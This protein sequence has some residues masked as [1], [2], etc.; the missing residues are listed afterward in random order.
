[1]SAETAGSAGKVIKVT[2]VHARQN[3]SDIIKQDMKFFIP[4]FSALLIFLFSIFAFTGIVKSAGKVIVLDPGHGG[5]DTGAVYKGLQEKT[6]TLDIAK[7]LKA[8]LEGAG[9]IVYLTREDDLTKSNN[10]RYTLANRVGGNALVSIHLNSSS[11]SSTD[12]TQGF[13]GKKTKDETFTKTVHNAL[14]SGLGVPNRGV[15]NFA[16]GVLLKSN[17]P[18][19]LQETVF[20]TSESEYQLLTDGSGNRQQQIARALFNGIKDWL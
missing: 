20:L 15:T 3:L 13:W 8:L 6:V 19:T 5:T 9:Y 2:K 16:S 1:M 12:G 4:I 11:N 18:A 14:A 10:D 17:M 7:R